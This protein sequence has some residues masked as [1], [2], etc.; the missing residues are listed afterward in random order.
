MLIGIGDRVVINLKNSG[1]VA[2][3]SFCD[4]GRRISR[5]PLALCVS[6]FRVWRCRGVGFRVRYITV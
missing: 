2:S 6:R 3:C 5:S 1:V 4:L